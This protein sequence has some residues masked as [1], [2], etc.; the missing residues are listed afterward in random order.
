MQF[1]RPTL[2]TLAN[3]AFVVVC[4]VFVAFLGQRMMQP[5][6]ASPEIP[7]GYAVGDA[8]PVLEGAPYAAND[9]T[10]ILFLATGCKFCTE[11][12]PFYQQLAAAKEG[13]YQLL[14]MGA[15]PESAMSEYLAKHKI[16]ADRVMRLKPGQMKVFATPTVRV[17]D[18]Q[19]KT[20]GQ[21]L[22]L[23]GTRESEVR[24]ALG[25]P[26]VVESADTR[27]SE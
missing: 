11:S 3:L 2:D 6:A 10:L 21:W 24:K 1:R 9:R 14:V 23:L 7:K 17:A 22:G 25:N 12:M 13:R 5:A 4:I 19:G 8:L 27:R 15:E 18:R 26:P 16:V 20:L